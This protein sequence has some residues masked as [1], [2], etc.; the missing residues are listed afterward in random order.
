MP[1]MPRTNA[2]TRWRGRRYQTSGAS[3]RR[4]RNCN[5]PSAVI[6]G[7]LESL[8]SSFAAERLRLREPERLLVP[9]TIFLGA[10]LLFEVEPLIAKMILPWFG[11]SAE[12]WIVCLLFS[13][14]RCWPAICMPIC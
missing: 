3:L 7:P 13:R 9:L 4:R 2:P 10:F 8:V 6:G 11:G 14:R 1:A 5:G 12:V